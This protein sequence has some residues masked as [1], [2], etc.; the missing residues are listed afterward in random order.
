MIVNRFFFSVIAL[1]CAMV[2]GAQ[3]EVM[4][5][6]L[7]HGNDVTAFQGSTAFKN[8]VDAADDGDVITLSQGVFTG[9][10]FIK[11][12]ISIYGAGFEEDAEAGTEKTETTGKIFI[13]ADDENTTISQIHF[14]GMYINGGEWTRL[15]VGGLKNG[16]SRPVSNLSISK[17]RISSYIQVDHDMDQITIDNSVIDVLYGSNTTRKVGNLLISNTYIT[18]RVYDFSNTRGLINHCIQGGY[19]DR[20]YANA[21]FKYQNC[22]FVSTAGYSNSN[23]PIY[24]NSIGSTVDHCIYNTTHI[25]GYY[26]I[27]IR[28][29]N[30]VVSNSIGVQISD[31][32]ADDTDG[33]YSSTRT[34]E[35]QKPDE[36]LGTD[37]TQI[38]ILGGNGFSKVPSTPVVKNITLGVSGSQ[39]NVSYEVDER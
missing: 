8:A 37:G 31:I 2:A 13:G 21:Q 39:L 3:N 16:S 10:I 11:K 28:T 17:C 20:D 18:N 38:G 5:A 15:Y 27:A 7:Q 1:C 35:L 34:F 12:S 29:E 32:F 23:Y 36:W 33:A 6:L 30:A 4:Y 24:H 26:G 25:G 19:Y 22:I 9:E 14:E